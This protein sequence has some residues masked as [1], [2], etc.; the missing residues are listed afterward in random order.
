MSRKCEYRQCC[1]KRV[2]GTS[3]YTT[4]TFIPVKYAVVGRKIELQEQNG[5]WSPIWTVESAS[6]LTKQASDFQT[7]EQMVRGHR[8]ATGDSTKRSDIDGTVGRHFAKK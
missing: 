3:T 6:E 7:Y 8:Q 5:D 4:V 1:L 2:D